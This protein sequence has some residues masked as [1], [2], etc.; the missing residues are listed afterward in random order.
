MPYY[1]WRYPLSVFFPLQFRKLFF[2]FGCLVHASF[3]SFVFRMCIMYTF[4]HLYISS[5]S[6]WMKIQWAEFFTL[7]AC[8]IFAQTNL[9]NIC[10]FPFSP[11]KCDTLFF[12]SYR[13]SVISIYQLHWHFQDEWV[14]C[15]R[16]QTFSQ[17]TMELLFMRFAM[18]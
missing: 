1:S 18:H 16:K 9:F 11:A 13:L 5:W 10:L 4:I 8:S 14:D 15:W 2:C 3:F 6:T 17:F 7:D 12:N